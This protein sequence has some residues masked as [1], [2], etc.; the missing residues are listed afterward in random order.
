MVVYVLVD[1]Y[2]DALVCTVQQQGAMHVILVIF[3]VRAEKNQR[4]AK[5]E[6]RMNDCSTFLRDK[7]TIEGECLAQPLD[8]SGRI[9]ITENGDKVRICRRHSL[10]N[11]RAGTATD[12]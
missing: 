10:V 3:V 6:L 11:F 4:I 2:V 1:C 8:R 5:A 9:A 12:G 7:A